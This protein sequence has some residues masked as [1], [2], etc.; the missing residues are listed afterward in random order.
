[1]PDPKKL[2]YGP[3]GEFYVAAFLSWHE[4]LV[5]LPR[6]GAK[7]IDLFVGTYD[8]QKHIGLQVKSSG[9]ASGKNKEGEW[10]A[11]IQRFPKPDAIG[12]DNLWYAYVNLN[13]W[14]DSDN[15]QPDIYFIPS[16]DVMKRMHAL[17]EEAAPKLEAG[18][19]VWESFWMLIDKFSDYKNE[20]GLASLKTAIMTPA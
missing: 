20:K 18:K 2:F 5:A 7:G 15:T 19:K 10:F 16:V 6:A 9:D 3:S 12:R 4:L 14:R 8:S 1:M 11:W 13:R 17:R